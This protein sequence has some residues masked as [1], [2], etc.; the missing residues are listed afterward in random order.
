MKTLGVIGGLGPM[1]TSYF[2]RRIVELTDAQ[3]DQ[4]LVYTAA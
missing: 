2:L 4:L 1:A 3:T